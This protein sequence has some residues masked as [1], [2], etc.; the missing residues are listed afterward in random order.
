MS[1]IHDSRTSDHPLI[2]TVWNSKNIT[3]GIYIATPDGAWDL[4]VMIDT[5]GDR[6]VMLTGQATKPTPVPYRAGTESIVISFIPGAYLNY[7][8]GE[9]MVDLI[10]MLPNF[11]DSHFNLG[12]HTFEIPAYDEVESLVEKMVITGVLKHDTVVSDVL[13]RK[14][15]AISPRVAQRHFVKTAGITQ[16]YLMQIKRA[17]DAVRFIQRGE[18]PIDAAQHAGYSDQPHLAKSLKKIMGSSPS[19]VDDIHKL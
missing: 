7:L 19:D 4:I 5:N 14:R 3:D 6:S 1:Q 2:E 12:G 8:S 18:R 16:N 13:S 10:E 15:T 17:Q 9:E 11:D